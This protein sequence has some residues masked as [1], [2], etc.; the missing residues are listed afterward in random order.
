M[1]DMKRRERLADHAGESPQEAQR[2]RAARRQLVQDFR[3]EQRR[4]REDAEASRDDP[5]QRGIGFLFDENDKPTT[6][7]PPEDIERYRRRLENQADW[8]QATLEEVLLELEAL[9]RLQGE[10]S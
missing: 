1:A 10:K 3:D 8:L 5:N 6:S 9:K 2:R 7:S 4:R